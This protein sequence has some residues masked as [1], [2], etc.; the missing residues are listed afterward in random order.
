MNNQRIIIADTDRNYLLTL[1]IKLLEEVKPDIRI[2]AISD[3]QFFDS[4]FSSPQEAGCLIVSENLYSQELRK[5]NIENIIILTE[6]YVASNDYT[7][8]VN[9]IYKYSRL[10]EIYNQIKDYLVGVDGENEIIIEKDTKVVSLVSSSGGQ[11][12]TTI[13]LSL[14]ACLSKKHYNVLY[15]SMQSIQNY[16]VFLNNKITL[17]EEVII[18]FAE[19]EVD[20]YRHLNRHLQKEEFYYIPPMPSPLCFYGIDDSFFLSVIDE[21]IKSKDFDYL[22]V[23]TDSTFNAS[24][25]K[26][27]QKSNKILYVTNQ[28][29]EALSSAISFLAKIDRKPDQYCFIANNNIVKEQRNKQTSFLQKDYS[30][31]FCNHSGKELVDYLSVSDSIMKLSLSIE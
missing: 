25:I 24:V 26:L 10:K 12:K 17:P 3:K 18:E 20:Y 28:T 27:I 2:D 7:H 11:G 8:L 23:D 16:Q 30:V 19:K 29:D 5:H 31:P 21:I 4:L 1:Q 13:A 6:D 22:I 14:A 15:I 9:R